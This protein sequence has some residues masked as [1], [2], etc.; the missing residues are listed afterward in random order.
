MSKF[1]IL[2]TL[3]LSILICGQLAQA[4]EFKNIE[5][6]RSLYRVEKAISALPP[7]Q[8][9]RI[10]IL[11]KAW[12]GVEAEVGKSL[13]A[14]TKYILGPVSAPA[15][16]KLNHGLRMAQ[17]VT[18]FLGSTWANKNL[19][20]ELYQVYGFTNFKSAIDQLIQNPPD[21]VLYSEVW[22][23]G[24]NSDGK[25]FINEQVNRAL[26]AKIKWIN[27]AGNFGDRTYN[28]NITTLNE[29]WVQLPDQNQSWKITCEAPQDKKCPLRV[30]LTWNDFKDDSEVGTDRDLDLALAD[31]LLNIIQTSTLKQSADKN[32]SR[33]G[34]SKYPREAI[35]AEV[36][37]GTYFVR[38]KNVS[39]NFYAKDRLRLT[40]DG[41]YIFVDSFDPNESLLN[42]ADNSGVL[43]IGALD[44][45]RTSRSKKLSRPDLWAVS[46]IILN[47]GQEFR[48]TSNAA[49]IFAASVGLTVAYN[50][51]QGIE[52]TRADLID[53]FG[54]NFDWHKGQI[55]LNEL[56]FGPINS[57]C[58][59]GDQSNIKS[60]QIKKLSS[61]GGTL[62]QTTDGWKMMFAFDPWSF[63]SIKKSFQDDRLM[64]LSSGDV[65]SYPRLSPLIPGAIELFA[66]PYEAGLC[67]VPEQKSGQIIRPF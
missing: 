14:N 34:Y 53:L 43:S 55:S 4:V 35:F 8:K 49:A 25:G 3:L 63:F 17:I 1:F 58:F 29:N 37:A 20:L 66:R 2:E 50:K 9:L 13:P 51:Q 67:Q 61:L 60:S 59:G 16:L 54:L 36:A 45:E 57:N 21:V 41:D 12:F 7:N 64:L 44:S 47:D 11:D 46:S 52:V 18:E 33:P 19:N 48:G 28:S 40:A 24:G 6:I 62:V 23:L 27:A 38:I 65:R 15:D 22:E 30:V 32:E 5:D 10:A 31:D 26:A 56:R 39:K 42:P